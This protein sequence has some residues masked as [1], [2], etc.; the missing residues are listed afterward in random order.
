MQL[1]LL[2][3]LDGDGLTCSLYYNPGRKDYA[4]WLKIGVAL[5]QIPQ[6]SLQD[7]IDVLLEIQSSIQIKE[8]G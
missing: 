6:E 4:I 2:E 7:V 5:L 8:N 3:R 1:E